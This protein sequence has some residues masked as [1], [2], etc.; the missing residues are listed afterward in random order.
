MNRQEAN[1]KLKDL[2]EYLIL[3]YPDLRFSQILDI[4]GF[5][6]PQRPTKDRGRISWQ[7]EFNMEPE[8]LLERVERRIKDNDF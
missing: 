5:V 7:N 8:E 4:A 2:L 6:K 3:K 1:I